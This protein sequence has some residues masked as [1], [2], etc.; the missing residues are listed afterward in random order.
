M[1]LNPTDDVDKLKRYR[2]HNDDIEVVLASLSGKDVPIDRSF[3]ER[4]S[5]I[6]NLSQFPLEAK[7]PKLRD[8]VREASRDTFN[9]QNQLVL[10]APSAI[11][12][13]CTHFELDNASFLSRATPGLIGKVD[14]VPPGTILS[15]VIPKGNSNVPLPVSRLGS[16]AEWDVKGRAGQD[17]DP[18]VE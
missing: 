13:L 1:T 12:D 16:L 10:V 14:D 9:N 18:Y 8:S 6:L 7:A 2:K 11:S 4:W 17:I 3:L 5:L 15:I